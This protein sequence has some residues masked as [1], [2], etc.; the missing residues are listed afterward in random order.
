MAWKF[1]KDSSRKYLAFRSLHTGK[2]SKCKSL[3]DD[4]R[5]ADYVGHNQLG[6]LEEE[7]PTM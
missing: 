5:V 4:E 3:R 6:Q 7:A 1:I 2:T